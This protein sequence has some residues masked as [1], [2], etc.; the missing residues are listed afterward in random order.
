ME[1]V[2]CTSEQSDAPANNAEPMDQEPLPEVVD[3][4]EDVDVEK[5]KG[6][7]FL[8]LSSMQ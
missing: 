2:D 3:L 7:Y 5:D 4:T 8:A 6:K 1:Q